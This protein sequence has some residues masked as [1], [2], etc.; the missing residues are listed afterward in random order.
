MTNDFRDVTS[1]AIKFSWISTYLQAL[2]F[3]APKTGLD[4][5]FLEYAILNKI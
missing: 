2:N 1:T 3:E 4:I 5:D